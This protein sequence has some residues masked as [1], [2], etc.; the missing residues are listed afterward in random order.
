MTRGPGAAGV[1][2]I[3]TSKGCVLDAIVAD[4]V[5]LVDRRTQKAA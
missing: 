1:A 2:R 3:D 5:A 4:I